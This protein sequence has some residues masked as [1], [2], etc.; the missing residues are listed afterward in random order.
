MSKLFHDTIAGIRGVAGL[1][2]VPLH[3][4]ACI[5]DLLAQLDS[6]MHRLSAQATQDFPLPFHPMAG[7]RLPHTTFE[8]VAPLTSTPLS[9]LWH[10]RQ[11]IWPEPRPLW[12]PAVAKFI[13]LQGRSPDKRDA[14]LKRIR[15]EAKAAGYLINNPHVVEL[16][17]S[18]VICSANGEPIVVA[19]VYEDHDCDLLAFAEQ[20]KYVF[21]PRLLRHLMWQTCEACSYLH[22]PAIGLV[23]RDIKPANILI[24]LGPGERTGKPSTGEIEGSHAGG[25]NIRGSNAKIADPGSIMELDPEAMDADLTHQGILGTLS[26]MSPEQIQ[27]TTNPASD[28]YSLGAAW[29]HAVSGVTPFSSTGTS[30]TGSELFHMLQRGEFPPPL[31]SRTSAQQYLPEPIITLIDDMMIREATLRPSATEC[32][33]RLEDMALPRDPEESLAQTLIFEGHIGEVAT[34]STSTSSGKLP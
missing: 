22:H 24:A 32:L 27:G 18:C 19:L 20:I 12:R 15:R 11:Q 17:Q 33:L 23:H 4:T 3:V 2:G 29:Y 7:M 26:Y 8:L 13:P 21:P 6:D 34:D 31:T 30:P 25:G 1:P 28:I 14:L 16:Y 10:V 5:T 9:S